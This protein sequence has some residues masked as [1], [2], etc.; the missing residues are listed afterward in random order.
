MKTRNVAKKFGITEEELD[1]GIDVVTNALFR[2]QNQKVF[3]AV[4]ELLAVGDIEAEELPAD[5]E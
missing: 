2:I 1:A 3:L 5:E 4:G